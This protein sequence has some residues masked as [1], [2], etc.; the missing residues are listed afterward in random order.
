MFQQIG[1]SIKHKYQFE[2]KLLLIFKTKPTRVPF[3]MPH[4]SRFRFVLGA[5]VCRKRGIRS[6]GITTCRVP[7]NESDTET[8]Q[9]N[10]WIKIYFP[11]IQT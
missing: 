3:S 5:T 7:S 11:F 6:P 8:S 10:N 9:I 1:V 4:V 2:E